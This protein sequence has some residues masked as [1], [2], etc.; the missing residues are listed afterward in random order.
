VVPTRAREELPAVPGLLKQIAGHSMWE[1]GPFGR[2]ACLG[3]Y[4]EVADGG[5][6]AVG[7]VMAFAP[8]SPFL[9]PRTGSWEYRWA[10]RRLTS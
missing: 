8:G 6:L 7:E 3:T 9:A 2:G 5:R 1:L 10:P 4:A